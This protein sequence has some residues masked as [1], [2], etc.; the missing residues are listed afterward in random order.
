MNVTD[1]R[2]FSGATGSATTPADSRRISVQEAAKMSGKGVTTIRRLIEKGTVE[3]KRDDTGQY[4]INEASFRN[5]LVTDARPGKS[6]SSER[7][8]TKQRGQGLEGPHGH[9]SVFELDTMKLLLATL[10]EQLSREQRKNDELQ[11]QIR[12]LE[13]ER[14]QHL[15]E[16]RALLSGK[17]EG[18]LSIKRWLG[19]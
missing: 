7:L 1:T 8:D 19:K 10:Q 12:A 18:I 13:G 17:S 15:A 9:Q 14:T 11:D 2:P 6:S 16:M 4:W 5:Y 3:A